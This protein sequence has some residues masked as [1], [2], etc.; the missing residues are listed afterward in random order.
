MIREATARRLS[1]EFAGR[2]GSRGTVGI[3]RTFITAR[4]AAAHARS[5]DGA[6]SQLPGRHC[7][8][9]QNR[10]PMEVSALPGTGLRVACNGLAAAGR[11]DTGRRVAASPRKDPLL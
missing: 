5:T 6:Q 11:M 9:A 4:K 8:S 2:N 3:N 7:V 10:L 1:H